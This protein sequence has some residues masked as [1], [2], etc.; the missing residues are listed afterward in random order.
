MGSTGPVTPSENETSDSIDESVTAQDPATAGD[1]ATLAAQESVE[2]HGHE[3]H[4]H[5]GHTHGEAGSGPS[6]NPECTR[7]LDVEVPAEKV[8]HAFARV[9]KGY[10]KRARI[11][12]FRAGKVPESVIR[13]RFAEAIRQDVL[14]DILPTEFR[15]ALEREGVHPVSQPQVT[16][17]HLV[18]GEPMR[19]QA[20]FETMPAVDVT[21]YGDVRVDR[22]DAT[23]SDAEVEAALSEVREAHATM[24]TVEEDR[25]L[26]DGDFAEVRFSGRIHDEATTGEADD[27]ATRP[28]QSDDSDIEIGGA[29]TVPAFSDA[30]RGTKVGQQVEFSMEYP[31]DFAEKR[32][33]GK[34][35]AYDLEV[36]AIR[37]KVLPEMDD[38][39]V[40]Q[41]GEF[42]TVDVFRTKLREQM[43][44]DKRR[45]MESEAKDRILASFVERFSFPVPESLLQQQ[46]DTRLDHG[47]R[48]LAA[49]G[50]STQQMRQLDFDA[51]R[52]G[53][54]DA[55][56][57]EVKSFL[58]LD[59]IAEI[60]KVEIGDEEME[61][62]LQVLAN[63]AQEPVE[64]LR[65]RLTEDG[66]LAR[67][68]EQLRREKIMNQL[69]DRL[70]A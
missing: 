18:D 55:A 39:F 59:R 32:L 8:G 11:P 41:L 42:E 29:N 40:K 6:L 23:V 43:E 47:L 53:Q 17:L 2:E 22:S 70:A 27:P 51:L 45:H 26:A 5:E 33:A 4:D 21:G 60:E 62:Q 44:R 1:S 36:K 31:E 61:E 65:K 69:F 50:M 52:A 13:R 63:Q 58:I 19:F 25:V 35:V 38:A 15:A 46:I 28:I 57:N 20:A 30:L 49:Q 10:R 64:S 14:E 66:G 7:H 67:I 56:L 9:V 48:A 34:T 54:R 37:K 16:S 68:R 3:H 12:G 24:E